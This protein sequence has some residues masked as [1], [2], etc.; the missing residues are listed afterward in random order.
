M[1]FNFG[2]LERKLFQHNAEPENFPLHLPTSFIDCVS[3]FDWFFLHN[4]NFTSNKYFFLR[5][6][7]FLN[8][9]HNLNDKKNRVLSMANKE[10][11]QKHYQNSKR[12]VNDIK[13]QIAEISFVVLCV[14]FQ[15]PL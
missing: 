14:I 7:F 11:R 15:D 6:F 10:A 12:V 1:I 5:T 13:F 8:K 4:T 2:C 3:L 9:N